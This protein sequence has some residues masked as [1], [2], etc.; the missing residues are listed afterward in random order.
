MNV[1]MQELDFLSSPI[2]ESTVQNKTLISN[3]QNFDAILQKATGETY[4]KRVEF[5][6]IASS[7]KTNQNDEVQNKSRIKKK[8]K[9]RRGLT[10]KRYG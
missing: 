2:K 8:Q 6:K 10:P 5:K 7:L 3:K 9:F 4:Y 1:S